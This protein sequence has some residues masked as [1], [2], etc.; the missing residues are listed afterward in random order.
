MRE[1]R[2]D[3]FERLYAQL[4]EL[5]PDLTELKPGDHRKSKAR[6]FMDLSLDVLTRSKEKMRIALAH[7][8]EQNGDLI[9]DPDMEIRVYLI[10]DCKKAEALT[11]QDSRRYDAVYPQPGKVHPRLRKSLNNFLKIWLTNLKI[12]GHSLTPQA[13]ASVEA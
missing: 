12:Q 11:Y 8:Y 6:G 3:R 9:P 5:I 1:K 2:K 4:T 13:L 7:N 10:D